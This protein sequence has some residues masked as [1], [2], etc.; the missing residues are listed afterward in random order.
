MF[1][2]KGQRVSEGIAIGEC[3][4]L[5]SNEVKIKEAY[6][7]EDKVEAEVRRFR[8]ALSRTEADIKRLRDQQDDKAAEV[9]MII[10]T[11]ISILQDV[12]L[13]DNVE[14]QIRKERKTAPYAVAEVLGQVVDRL[15]AI[16][17][18][19]ISSKVADITDV[20]R[21]L[22]DQMLGGQLVK[23]EKLSRPL[24][25]VADDITPTQTATLDR[26]KVLGFAT[27]RGSWVSH[28]AILARALGIPAVVGVPEIDRRVNLGSIVIVDGFTGDVVVDPDRRT[29]G[30]Y[31]Q[32]KKR[33]EKRSVG[34][35]QN[36]ALRSETRDGE[37]CELHGN[38]ETKADIPRVLESGGSGV[39]LFR[40]EFLYLGR[41]EP[42]DEEEQ[43]EEYSKAAEAVGPGTLTIRSMDFGGDKFDRRANDPGEPNPF[44]GERAIRVSFK[45]KDL[46]L[47]QLRAVLRAAVR[48]NVR[49]MFP[50][51]MDLGEFRRAKA[52]V[53]EARAELESEGVKHAEKLPLGTMIELPC[54]ALNAARLAPEVDFFSIGTN[55]LTQFSLGVDRTNHRVSHLFAPWHPGVL[56]LIREVSRSGWK[57]KR[58][59]S[60][61]GEM[62]GDPL[63]TPL[64]LGVGIR[65]F[66]CSARHIPAVKRVIRQLYLS[67]CIDLAENA[68]HAD[69]AQSVLAM[70]ETFRRNLHGS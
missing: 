24:V 60:V 63:C 52:C 34:D 28:T 27:E 68:L 22:L 3:T 41:T 1:I 2:L 25:I 15:K 30:K 40:T 54:A 47:V 59:V 12:H 64:L 66:S 46:F 31:R 61:C 44:M 42:P 11:H 70:L 45:R 49:L 16:D 26:R 4:V 36:R 53:D 38:I 6:V 50:M 69:D 51:I 19:M 17:N 9:R 39:G 20:E 13:I 8:K 21:R 5:T 7:P 55:D 57:Q 23:V 37:P 18:P 65:S 10:D 32:M 56:R 14:R 35:V 48:G 62:A 29:L 33:L 43:F 58:P 67:R